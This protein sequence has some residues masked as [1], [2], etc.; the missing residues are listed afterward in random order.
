MRALV[1]VI[2]FM[3]V[4][5]CERARATFYVRFVNG[6]CLNKNKTVLDK[7]NNNMAYFLIDS[8]QNYAVYV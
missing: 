2:V 6:L 8:E 1:C 4:C 3:C 5:V 7:F